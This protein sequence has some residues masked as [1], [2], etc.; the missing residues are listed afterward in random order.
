L[1]IA[2]GESV[3]AVGIGAADFAVTAG[4][5]LAATL[6]LVVLAGLWWCY[7]ADDNDGKAERAL[8]AVSPR[9]RAR[10]SL[11]AFG[12]CYLPLLGGVIIFAAGVKKAVSQPLAAL[13]VAPAVAIGGGAA[14]YLVGDMMLRRVLRLGPNLTRLAVAVLAAASCGVG[15]TVSA[16]GQLGVLA[17][18]VTMLVIAER[19]VFRRGAAR[20]EESPS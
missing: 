19:P 3:V 14:L 15:V 18:V 16:V 12:H 6:T 2:F 17:A 20:F 7:F 11:L 8:A 1:I 5:V 9:R 10:L 4:L 13:S